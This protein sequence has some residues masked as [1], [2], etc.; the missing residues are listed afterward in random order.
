M[1]L[2]DVRNEQRERAISAFVVDD[3]MSPI[4]SQ[5][6]S[7]RRHAMNSTARA[8]AARPAARRR[9]AVGVDRDGELVAAGRAA[10]D[11]G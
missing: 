10:P 11:G 7:G 8:R 2:V 4:R 3:D 1:R 6:S 5:R 9:Q